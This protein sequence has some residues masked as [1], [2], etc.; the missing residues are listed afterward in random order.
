MRIL[1][2]QGRSAITLDLARQ[3]RRGGHSVFVVDTIAHTVCRYS[4]AVAQ[5]FIVP[6][7]RRDTRKFLQAVRGIVKKARIERIIPVFEET[8]YLAEDSHL[9][10]L[11]YAA[12]LDVLDQLHNKY[13]FALA[14]TKAGVLAAPTTLVTQSHHLASLDRRHDYALKPCYA[15]AA[16]DLVRFKPG[17]SATAFE[18]TAQV[19]YVAQRWIDGR[20][21]CSYSVCDAG[22]V[23]AHVVYPVDYTIDGHSCV[24]FRPVAHGKID[25]WVTKLVAALSY[26]G[27]IAIDFIEA[28][29]GRVW[30]I[31]CNPR[32]TSG[33]HLLSQDR[34][35]ATA[36]AGQT[37]AGRL[38]SAF[39]TSIEPRQVMFGMLLY[40]WRKQGRTCKTIGAYLKDLCLT[41]DVVFDWRDLR[42]WVMQPLA[43]WALWRQSRQLG[44]S[45]PNAFLYDFEWD[46]Q[47][48]KSPV[49][50]TPCTEQRRYA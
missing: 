45:L 12:P 36:L 34:R 9:E 38:Q 27:Q 33:V 40:A 20:R 44:I 11:L 21:Y 26:T 50:Q 5:Y 41:R 17:I 48:Q 31:E 32:A 1:L 29:D 42:P 18:L 25:A 6:S 39:Q 16:Q 24:Y 10:H 4:A 47:Q 7:P 19:P 43:L 46:A 35:L 8:L 28:E 14:A 15:R 13:T 3:L 23:R 30:A 49:Q 2:T 22:Q 37:H